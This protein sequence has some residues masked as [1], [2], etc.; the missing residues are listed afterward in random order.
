MKIKIIA[1][2]ADNIQFKIRLYESIITVVNKKKNSTKALEI[3]IQIKKKKKK[4]KK[5]FYVR[6]L[7]LR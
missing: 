5:V 7:N 6:A 1:M 2:L 4:R 3:K